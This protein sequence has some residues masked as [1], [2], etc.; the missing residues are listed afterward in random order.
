MGQH[1]REREI[2]RHQQYA[3]VR[4]ASRLQCFRHFLSNISLSLWIASLRNGFHRTRIPV[5]FPTKWHIIVHHFKAFNYYFFNDNKLMRL[6]FPRH[7]RV[8][9]EKEHTISAGQVFFYLQ[10]KYSC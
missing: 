3:V 9:R 10:L 5:W 4:L 6:N 1:F 2:F 7:N 8:K